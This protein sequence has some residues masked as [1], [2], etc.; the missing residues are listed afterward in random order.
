MAVARKRVPV[1]RGGASGMAV[2]RAQVA[3]PVAAELPMPA[4][5]AVARSM[6]KPHQGHRHQ[7][8][9]T[10]YQ[11]QLIDKQRTH[12]PATTSPQRHF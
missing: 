11:Q 1:R 5:V 4:V 2:A 12:L 3:V 8:R 9:E 10:R 7:A 6:S